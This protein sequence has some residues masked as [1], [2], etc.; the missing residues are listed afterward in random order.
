[1]KASYEAS[2]VNEQ[3]IE[4]RQVKGAVNTTNAHER[5]NN[6]GKGMKEAR[7]ERAHNE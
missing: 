2:A 1:M 4:L 7:R 3:T 5:N 6:E